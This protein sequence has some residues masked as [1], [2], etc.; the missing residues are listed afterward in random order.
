[1]YLTKEQE[2][3]LRGEYGWAAAKALELIIRVGDALGAEELVEIKHA[4]VSGVSYS[5]VGRYGLEFVLDFY[6]KGGRAKVY[7]T[8]NPGCIDYSGLSRIIDNRYAEEQRKIDEALIGMGFKPVFTCIPYYYRP[9]TIGEHLAWGES[10]A[11][12]YANSFFGAYTNREGG[13]IALAASIVGYTYK[14]GL[15]LDA[16]RVAKV[17]VEVPVQ[18]LHLPAGALGLC[19]GEFIN[20]APYVTG[21]EKVDIGEVKA[22]LA[23]MASAGSHAFAVLEG[24]T[25]RNTYSLELEDK[26]TVEKDVLEKYLGDDVSG[27]DEVLG[28]I[29]CPHTHPAELLAVVR[30]LRKYSCPK[31]GKLLVTIPREYM[32]KFRSIVYE[33]KARGV[34]VATGTCP[35]VSRLRDKFD[36]VVTNSGKAAFYIKRVHGIKVRLAKLE[37]VVRY[38]YKGRS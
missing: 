8:I 27:R 12:I 26:I 14:A 21:F 20:E 13:P 18:L 24:I 28:Y 37:E 34:D 32:F 31:K 30:L 25:P 29:G 38:V 19:I 6:E 17:K 9:P 11:V 35:V 1:M 5:N 10:S 23:S 2:K 16:N 7:T 4:H 3:I 36:V 15:H 33:L 22:L